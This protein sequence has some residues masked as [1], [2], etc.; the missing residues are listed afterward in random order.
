MTEKIFL[1][2][3]KAKKKK[4]VVVFGAHPDDFEVGCA[5]TILKYF[6]DINLRIYVMSDRYEDGR[7][8]DLDDQKK[9]F[10]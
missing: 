3:N 5:G 2:N 9:A 8:R 4:N 1:T 10:T 7:L 6:K